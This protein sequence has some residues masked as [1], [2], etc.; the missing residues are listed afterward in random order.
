MNKP[1]DNMASEKNNEIYD[2]I[3]TLELEI[4]SGKIFSLSN[5]STLLKQKHGSEYSVQH[6]V[7]KKCL[8][9]YFGEKI[10]FVYPNQKN[11]SQLFHSSNINRTIEYSYNRDS[12][13]E[14]ADILKDSLKEVTFDLKDRFC[15]ENDLRSAWQN[16]NISR[17]FLTFFAQ[18]FNVQQSDIS[19]YQ[20][21]TI[22][23]ND[24]NLQKLKCLKLLR[25][26][27]LFQTL[28][29][30]FS[31]GNKEPL[32]VLI[33]LFVYHATKSKTSIIQLNRL[34][35]SIPYDDI[36]RIRTRLVAYANKNCR[37][38]VPIPSH[39]DPN[40]YVTAAFD[41]F[42][43]IETSISGLD[44]THDTVAVIFQNYNATY[45]SS[46]PKVSKL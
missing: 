11:I 39:F 29:Y 24:E 15:D 1:Q 12:I 21:N 19:D 45:Y 44:S 6:K 9:K 38:S 31:N 30:T 40:S 46:K 13:I 43:H 2:I 8:I 33:G 28:Y 5:I 14:C 42:D 37:S 35:V 7:I 4:D 36:F 26:Q 22:F 3:Q 34:G 41:N 23:G 16:V 32:H 10:S 18:L 27:T 25:I 17:P 20:N